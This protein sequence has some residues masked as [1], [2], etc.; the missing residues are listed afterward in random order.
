MGVVVV[1]FDRIETKSEKKK[2]KCGRE[3]RSP[4]YRYIYTTPM[5]F[6]FVCLFTFYLFFRYGSALSHLENTS[7][8]SFSLP[9][10]YIY[11]YIYIHI[12]ENRFTSLCGER[13]PKKKK[14]E[15][16]KKTA[17][18][19]EERIHLFSRTLHR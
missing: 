2:K 18:T 5:L 16:K 6:F 17:N 11:I 12:F 19:R 4:I 14:K 15:E 13:V 9:L 1:V 7:T 3:R 8:A 10:L